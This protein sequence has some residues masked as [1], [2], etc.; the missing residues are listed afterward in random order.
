[1]D[2][3]LEE[4]IEIASRRGSRYFK[5][6]VSVEELPEKV[7]ELGV[8]LLEESRKLAGLREEKLRA[9]L[10]EIQNKMDDLRKS[11]FSLKIFPK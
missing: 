6:E 7:A 1:M 2:S 9:E 5:G 8:L 11:V 4:L 3:K 10:I